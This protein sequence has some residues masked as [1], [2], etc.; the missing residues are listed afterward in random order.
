MGGLDVDA[1]RVVARSRQPSGRARAN[2]RL[3]EGE[4]SRHREVPGLRVRRQAVSLDELRTR[5]SRGEADGQAGETR[6]QPQDDVPDGW[7]SP[8]HSAP[9]ARWRHA[10]WQ[11]RLA[12]ARLSLP[13][14]DAR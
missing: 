1:V 12:A 14:V 6:A 5:G 11:A 7:S 2:V 13:T 4:R 9:R 10:R 3:A 8:A